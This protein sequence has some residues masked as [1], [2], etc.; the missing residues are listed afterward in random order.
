MFDSSVEPSSE[1]ERSAQAEAAATVPATHK[2][3]RRADA[4]T[5]DGSQ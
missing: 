4:R 1:V 2:K 5:P 3:R